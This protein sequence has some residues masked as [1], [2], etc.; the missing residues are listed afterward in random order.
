[1]L[2]AAR[3]GFLPKKRVD[4]LSTSPQAR[5]PDSADDDDP[6]PGLPSSLTA[7]A[8]GATSPSA[9][10][11]SNAKALVE[12]IP[13]TPPAEANMYQLGDD[14]DDDLEYTRNPFDEK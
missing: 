6:N 7:R 10:S 1:M 9:P 8:S 12:Q 4:L 2:T 3:L 13:K 14:D 11:A 5:G